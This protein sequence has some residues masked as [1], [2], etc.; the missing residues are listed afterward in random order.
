[1]RTTVIASLLLS[2]AGIARADTISGN[3]DVKYEEVSTNCGDHKLTYGNGKLKVEVKGKQLLV[4]IDRTPPMYGTPAANGK[5]SAKS[6]IGDTM[7]GGMKG[8]FSVAGH[9]TPEGQLS[10]M[11]IGE[12][13]ADGKPLCTQS[14]NVSGPKAGTTPA[15]PTTPAPPPKK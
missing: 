5:I 11:M 14:W 2:L 7:L 8:I 12:F 13:S 9:I 4:D 1:M 6:R 10:L 15:K 3:Y